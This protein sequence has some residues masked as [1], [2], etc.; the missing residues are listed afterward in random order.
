MC[1]VFR[2]SRSGF[3][4][5]IK[6][7]PSTQTLAN[8][9][10]EQDI[11]RIYVEN[12]G[13]YGAPRIYHELRQKGHVC[14]KNRVARRMQIVGLQAK[15]KRQYRVT[16]NSNH[17]F[18]VSPNIVNRDFHATAMNQK[19]TSD[20]TYVYTGEGWLYVAVIIDLYS[21]AV[22]GWSMNERM[23]QSFVCDALMMALWRRGFPKN[24]ILHS[25]RGSQYC[26]HQYQGLMQQY[27]LISSMSRKANCW[28]NA[29]AESFFHTLKVELIHDALFKTRQEATLS[30]F[31]YIET[32]YN[33]KRAH[34]AIGFYAPL[35]FE[36]QQKNVA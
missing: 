13:R 6:R 18:E 35:A 8:Q 22:I 4:A 15:A 21:R 16:T 29:P 25:D 11:V 1:Q 27:S 24:V 5:W 17:R 34:S 28:D 12:K 14:S 20:I 10:L 36:L 31:E 19:W 32:Y 26:S 30:I 2:L 7:E 23:T 3:Y 33:N 9:Q